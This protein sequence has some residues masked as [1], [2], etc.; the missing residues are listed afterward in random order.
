[1]SNS[2]KRLVL[3][4]AI[5]AL[6]CGMLT[7]GVDRANAKIGLSFTKDRY[8][9]HEP[10]TVRFTGLPGTGGDW[11]TIVPH[12]TPAN[13]YGEWQY[14]NGLQ[15]GTLTFKG[16]A[17]GK[18]EV[19]AYLNWPSGG[20]NIAA[21]QIFYVGNAPVPAP[22][23]KTG[24]KISLSTNRG[25]YD[26]Y[27][28]ILVTFSGLPGTSGDW[29]TIV[30]VGTPANQYGEWQYSDGRTSGTMTFKGLGPGRYE[31]RVYLNWP[32]GGYNIA[33]RAYFRVR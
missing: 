25:V 14:A 15:S 29:L 30:P 17:P 2:R 24:S 18:Y 11:L 12:G 7:M 6:T 22:Q 4:L 26:T 8:V 5:A 1:M 27:E 32:S 10:I 28:Q 3:L 16:L 19:R 23:P 13:Q 33:Q 20:Y 31:V 21:R 9:A